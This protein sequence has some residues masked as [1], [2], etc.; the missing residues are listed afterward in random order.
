MENGKRK[1]KLWNGS[2]NFNFP[3]K[4]PVPLINIFTVD[5]LGKQLASS[6]VRNDLQ[7]QNIYQILASK[8]YQ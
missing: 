4:W 6:R 3:E 2:Y 5:G 8:Q 7:P 1:E